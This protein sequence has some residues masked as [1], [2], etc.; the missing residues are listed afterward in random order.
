ML[1]SGEHTIASERETGN[2]WTE[3]TDGDNLDPEA[4]F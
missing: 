2:R 3:N 4:K 1:S